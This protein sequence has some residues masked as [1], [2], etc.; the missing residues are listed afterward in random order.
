MSKRAELRRQWRADRKNLKRQIAFRAW[1]P[2][3][4]DDVKSAIQKATG[5]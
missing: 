5:R 4:F 3:T 1:T 2:A